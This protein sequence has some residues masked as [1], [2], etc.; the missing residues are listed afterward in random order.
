M[1]T[2]RKSTTVSQDRKKKLRELAMKTFSAKE[3]ER[4]FKEKSGQ[5]AVDS[6][7]AGSKYG[8]P[9]GYGDEYVAAKNN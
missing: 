4:M 5:E 2:E 1:E 3:L 8:L 7:K 6:A 9:E